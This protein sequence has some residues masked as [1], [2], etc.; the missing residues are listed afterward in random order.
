MAID[1]SAFFTKAGKAFHAGNTLNTAVA[2]SVPAEVEDFTQTFDENTPIAQENVLAG[3]LDAL[4][5][6]QSESGGLIASAVR[7]PI[8]RLLV[9]VVKADNQQPTDS[10]DDAIA[11]LIRQMIASGDDVDAGSVSITPTQAGDGIIV[12]STKRPDGRVNELM[13]AEDILVSVLSVKENNEATLQLR[14]EPSVSVTAAD[15]PQGSGCSTSLL[16]AIAESGDNL[17]SGG[18]MEDGDAT[19]TTLP[20]GWIVGVGV[21]GTTVKLT[22]VE[23][24]TITITGSPSAG[25]YALNFTNRDGKVQQTPPIAYNG[26]ATAV[27][28]ALRAL[29]GLETVEVSSAGTSPNFVHTVTFYDCP[30]PGQLT[31]TNN[32]TGGSF[33]HATPTAGSAFVTRGA[34]SLEFDSDGAEAT[35]IYIPVSVT[36]KTQYAAHLYAAVDVVPAAGVFTVDLV[37]GIGGSVIADD[38]ATNNSFTFNAAD[39]TTTMASKSG[40][41]RTPSVLPALVFLRIRASTAVS[42]GTSSFIDEVC[43]RPMTELYPGGPWA[44]A[45]SG[46][47]QWDIADT[48]NLAIANDEG[49]AIHRWADRVFDLRENNLL[50]PTDSGGTETI[51]DSLIA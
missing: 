35:A 40:A 31:T 42:A 25:W 48:G 45:F 36:A 6:W 15:F 9:E 49:G 23:V 16:A 21:L 30:N 32:T 50:L 22:N 18:S 51:A 37:D 8:R 41:F 13:L 3:V 24:Q 10:L 20:E 2:T 39:L 27:Q 17:V 7:D 28:F 12:T 38:Q 11:E 43:L 1:F 26:S 19:V 29:A 4:R 14:G 44:A 47:T 34:R 46:R 5:A 33:A